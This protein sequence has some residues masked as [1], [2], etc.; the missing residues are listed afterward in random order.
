MAERSDFLVIGA[1]VSG[2]A[3]AAELALNGSVT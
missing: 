1:G 3:A 2:A